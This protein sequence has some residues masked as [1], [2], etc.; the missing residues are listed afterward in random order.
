MD[1]LIKI[2][3]VKNVLI[4]LRGEK[5][6]LDMDVAKLYGVTTREINQ[7]VR[8]NPDK[9]PEGYV[10]TPDRKEY[11]NLRSKFLTTKISP[12]SR[13]VPKAFTEKGLYMLA[14]ILKIPIATQTTLATDGLCTYRANIREGVRPD[15]LT[16][17]RIGD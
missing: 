2:G 5:V 1:K 12:K 8:N 11:I 13:Q 9:F 16:P 14:T 4:S 3:N 15:G 10:L 6:I 7:A 17:S